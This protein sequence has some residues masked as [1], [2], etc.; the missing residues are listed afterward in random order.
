[1]GEAEGDGEQ[2]TGP[3][4]P[5]LRREQPVPEERRRALRQRRQDPGREQ[6]LGQTKR[7]EDA[8]E[9]GV[10]RRRGAEDALAGLVDQAAAMGEVL[11]VAEGDQRVLVDDPGARQ[12]H[13][14]ESDHG[15]EDGSGDGDG[16]VW[17]YRVPAIAGG[18][19]VWRRRGRRGGGLGGVIGSLHGW[20][21]R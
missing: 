13:Q 18:V 11:R 7:A 12:E 20:R 5:R 21:E 19:D 6:R 17:T 1:G 8:Q 3:E 4:S 14:A 9:Q 10:E 16:D 2:A 15:E